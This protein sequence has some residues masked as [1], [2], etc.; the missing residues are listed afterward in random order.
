MRFFPYLCQKPQRGQAAIVDL[1]AVAPRDDHEVGPPGHASQP[2]VVARI[3]A[4]DPLTAA[5]EPVFE[6]CRIVGPVG[7]QV[8]DSDPAIAPGPGVLAYAAQCRVIRF[9]AERAGVE[10]DPVNQPL[11]AWRQ[12][13]PPGQTL[14][15]PGH[16]PGVQLQSPRAACT[17]SATRRRASG[18]GSGGMP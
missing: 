14:A 16:L 15:V 12:D 8:T 2:A 7:P 6:L 5:V 1:A 4:S 13:A 17:G 9:G 3:R 18:V 11:D 10:R